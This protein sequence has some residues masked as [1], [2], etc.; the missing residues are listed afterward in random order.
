MTNAINSIKSLN[1][2]VKIMSSRDFA[3]DAMEYIDN[4]IEGTVIPSG[5]IDI[6]NLLQG[7]Q[8]PELIVIASRPGMGKT[9]F[10]DNVARHAAEKNFPVG[11]I[12]LEMGVTQTAVRLVSDIGNVKGERI[13]SG[14]INKD[15]YMSIVNA[16]GKSV[17]FPVYRAFGTMTLEQIYNCVKQMVNY[18]RVKL[19]IVD[20]MQLVIPSGGQD[21]KAQM[22]HIIRGAKQICKD[23]NIPSIW[24]AQL[25]CNCELR[26]NKRPLLSDLGELE[27]IE[28]Y[29]DIV[30]FLYRDDYYT[31]KAEHTG[32]AEFIVAKNINGET[33]MRRL[34]WQPEYVRFKDLKESGL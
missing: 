19:I 3:K 20:Y 22:L 17:D 8:A 25:N 27:E 18:H 24:L 28:R 21:R 4:R 26:E 5:F 32:I 1:E 13:K 2:E 10:K 34:Q 12:E 33:G 15:E 14:K 29:A 11:I 7:W 16:L 30:V 9:A 31:Q 23:L 6:D